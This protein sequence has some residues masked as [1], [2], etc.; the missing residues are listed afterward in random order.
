[1]T[2]SV[3][4]LLQGEIYKGSNTKVN[5]YWYIFY[6]SHNHNISE[7][8][9]PRTTTVYGSIYTR[10]YDLDQYDQEIMD[11]IIEGITFN[12]LNRFTK[13]HFYQMKGIA[14]AEYA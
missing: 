5:V 8:Y 7:I 1:M 11:N 2:P 10:L 3:S 6:D 9:S 13:V 12:R 4:K 14:D